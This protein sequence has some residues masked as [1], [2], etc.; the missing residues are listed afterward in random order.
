MRKAFSSPALL[1]HRPWREQSVFLTSSPGNLLPGKVRES[2]P[3]P[4]T[5]TDALASLFAA[6][7]KERDFLFPPWVGSRSLFML[8]TTEDMGEG[9][10]TPQLSTSLLLR[11]R[12]P[13]VF[14]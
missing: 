10:Y 8:S 5:E 12:V 3:F 6:E 4:W 1:N 2:W 9:K 13:F 7:L 14:K 11:E